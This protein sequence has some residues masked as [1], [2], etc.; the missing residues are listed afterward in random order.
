[1]HKGDSPPACWDDTDRGAERGPERK[2]KGVEGSACMRKGR[3]KRIA[4]RGHI[5]RKG[6]REKKEYMRKG[7]GGVCV[8]SSERCGYSVCE[9]RKHA[10]FLKG[11]VEEIEKG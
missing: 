10:L 7:R 2:N 1:V 9:G 4:L 8:V 6:G 5:R 3:K 11:E